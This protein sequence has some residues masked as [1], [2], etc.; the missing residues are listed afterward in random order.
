MRDEDS[1]REKDESKDIIKLQPIMIDEVVE[2]NFSGEIK[3]FLEK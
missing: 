1:Q 2:E 3:A